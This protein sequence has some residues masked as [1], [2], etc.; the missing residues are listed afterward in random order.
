MTRCAQEALDWG[1]HCSDNHSDLSEY[2]LMRKVMVGLH[3]SAKF[4]RESSVAEADE[5]PMTSLRKRSLWLL[6]RARQHAQSSM[7]TA[8]L[9]LTTNS[10]Q[11]ADS[12][13]IVSRGIV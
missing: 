10:T 9:P 13:L 6:L 1:F 2:M 11:R 7:V 3:N 8:I 12:A 5:P 4:G